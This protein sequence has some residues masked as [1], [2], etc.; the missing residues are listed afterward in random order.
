M[1]G[2]NPLQWGS[3][4]TQPQL[5][6]DPTQQASV[7]MGSFPSG[8]APATFTGAPLAGTTDLE[9]QIGPAQ[10]TF[11]GKIRGTSCCVC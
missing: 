9:N 8:A 2:F 3:D 4:P 1:G 6:P 5:A 7:S 11:P 10:Q